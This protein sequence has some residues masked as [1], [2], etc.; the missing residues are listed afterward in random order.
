MSN[1]NMNVPV[2]TN[3][4]VHHR[5]GDTPAAEPDSTFAAEGCA[6]LAGSVDCTSLFM[7]SPNE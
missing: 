3:P 6:P 7:K 2:V 5:V 4:N 1:V